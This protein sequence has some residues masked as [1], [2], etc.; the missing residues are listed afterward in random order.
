VNGSFDQIY[1]RAPASSISRPS[2]NARNRGDTGTVILLIN[3]TPD[4]H[5]TDT[6]IETS[7]GS[8]VLDEAAH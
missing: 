3:V 7:S 5:A 6:H 8:D 4:G 2:S 1:T